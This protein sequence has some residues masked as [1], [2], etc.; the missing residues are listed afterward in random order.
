MSKH[1]PGPL[2]VSVCE[3]WPF[4][5]V[6]IDS[7]GDVVFSRDLPCH[8]TNHRNANEAMAGKGMPA[9]WKA[10]ERNARALAD[11]ILRAAAPELLKELKKSRAEIWRLLDAKAI[12]PKQAREWPEI[13]SA[14]AAIAKAT[15]GEE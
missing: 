2:T 14:D 5:I 6:T 15:G 13:V 8:S 3:E 1:T 7:R 11:E 12:A 9:E 10:A 4:K